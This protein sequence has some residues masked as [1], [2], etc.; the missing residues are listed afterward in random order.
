M[1]MVPSPVAVRLYPKLSVSDFQK[2]LILKD[3]TNLY[4]KNL[5]PSGISNFTA[6]TAS[7]ATSH[8]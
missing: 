5:K 7:D 4:F 8:S 1:G 6:A 3:N 2:Q